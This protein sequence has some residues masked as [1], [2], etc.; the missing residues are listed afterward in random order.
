[1]GFYHI[2]DES[3]IEINP[4][5]ANFY[6]ERACTYSV[7][8]L[9]SEDLGNYDVILLNSPNGDIECFGKKKFVLHL[10]L[11]MGVLHALVML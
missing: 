1:M 7:L 3:A 10:Q 11:L 4:V 5:H 8:E 9:L 2:A 6:Q